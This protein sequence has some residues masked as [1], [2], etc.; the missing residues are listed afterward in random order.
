[1]GAQLCLGAG[2]AT[3]EAPGHPGHPP[4]LATQLLTENELRAGLKIT[5]IL[6]FSLEMG[7]CVSE[8]ECL[9]LGRS[10]F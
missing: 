5:N 2:C 3:V 8:Q 9:R 4:P 7:V 10:I 1:M 6:L